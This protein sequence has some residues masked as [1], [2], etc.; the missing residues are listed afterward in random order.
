MLLG[1][2]FKNGERGYINTFYYAQHP[3]NRNALKA[4]RVKK[5]GN[6]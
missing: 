5:H 3:Q 4:M 1:K 2:V 6:V